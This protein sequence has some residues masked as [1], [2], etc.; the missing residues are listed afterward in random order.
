MLRYFRI[1]DPYRLIIIFVVLILFRLPFLLSSAWQT[2]PELSWMIVGERMNE[3]ALLYVGIWDNIGPLAAWIFQ[4]FDVLFGR[5]HLSL[6]IGGLLLFFA[7]IF[8]MNYLALK[9]KMYNENNYLPAFFYGLLGLLVFDLITLSPPLMGMTFVLLSMNSLFSHVESRNKVDGNLLNM[10]IFLGIAALFYLPYFLMLLVLIVG[11]LFFTNT[12]LRRYLLLLYGFGIPLLICWLVY[13]RTGNTHELYTNYF[14][15]LFVMDFTQYLSYKSI[16]ILS[17][18]TIFLF[19]IAALKTLS[20]FGFTVFQVRVQK[21]MFF[22]ALVSLFT[23]IFYADKDGYSLIIFFPW[24][25][26]FLS[27]FFLSIRHRLKR[28]IGFLVYF[29]SIV[30]VYFSIAFNWFSLNQLIHFDAIILKSPANSEIYAG[31]KILVFGPDI[32]PYSSGKQATAYFNWNLSRGQLEHLNYY[33]NLEAVDKNFR[34]DMPEI[35]IDQAGIAPKLF[36]LNPLL[37]AEY[38]QLKSRIYRRISPSN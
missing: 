15:G 30:I 10:G 1:N 21:V 22:A 3:G 27:H 6:Q 26:F 18:A 25:A 14:R 31:K 24:V 33:D 35:I 16:L 29:L 34:N 5:S 20:G 2:I 23:Y 8:Y 36:E 28:E 12:I 7:Q 17:G 19:A 4:A 9:H 32:Q 37:G 13:L 11:L 38:E